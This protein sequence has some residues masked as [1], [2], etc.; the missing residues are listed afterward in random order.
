LPCSFPDHTSSPPP[1]ALAPFIDRFWQW[2]APAANDL[3]FM[4]P[5]TGA[6]C[7]FHLCVPFSIN[8]ETAPASYLIC[9]RRQTLRLAA[10]GPV[11]F[12]AAR[13]RAGQLRHFVPASFSELQ[14][15]V[16]T[17]TDLWPDAPVLH[18][19]LALAPDFPKRAHLLGEFFQQQLNE[20]RQHL[21]D[22]LLGRLYYLPNTR[23]EGLAKYTGWTR[24]NLDKRFM[25]L[26]GVSPKY[27][28]RV[29]RM[30]QVARRLALSPHERL[31]D[32]ALDVGYFDQAHFSHDLRA[33]TGL[34]P[35][36]LRAVLT[37]PAH[38]YHSRNAVLPPS[39][40]LRENID[41]RFIDQCPG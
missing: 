31:F 37:R 10:T 32:L 38:F 12:V 21:L 1:P 30:Q 7:F 26:Y 11:N 9:N 5:G 24:S 39:P 19:Q 16:T 22:K 35:C 15:R 27:F 17:A 18:E 40:I 2:S 4:L 25:A 29:A 41:E 3:P 23:I 6:E 13:F 33:L 14:D 34:S 36:D 8:G 28:A 20:K